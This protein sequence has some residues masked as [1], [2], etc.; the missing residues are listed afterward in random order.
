MFCRL[1]IDHV[2]LTSQSLQKIRILRFLTNQMCTRFR[3][4]M[5]YQAWPR[6][7]VSTLIIYSLTISVNIIKPT[8]TLILTH[9]IVEYKHTTVFNGRWNH[10][11]IQRIG[12]AYAR[13]DFMLSQKNLTT[14]NNNAPRWIQHDCLKW[15]W[16]WPCQRNSFS[17]VD[18]FGLC[19][20]KW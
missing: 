2:F 12:H 8:L 3:T 15:P 10:Y 5:L 4:N 13:D 16:S 1:T 18:Y 17:S 6:C 19:Y 14:N 11:N 9:C 20:M 7:D